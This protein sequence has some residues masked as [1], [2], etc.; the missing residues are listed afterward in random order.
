MYK[1]LTGI[2][3]WI[4]IIN[5]IVTFK[6]YGSADAILPMIA[7]LVGAIIFFTFHNK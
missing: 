1:V 5:A 2:G 4:I 6:L 7:V 3:L